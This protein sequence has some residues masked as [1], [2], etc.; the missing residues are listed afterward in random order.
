M[1]ASNFYFFKLS[2]QQLNLSFKSF[3]CYFIFYDNVALINVAYFS[4]SRAVIVRMLVLLPFRSCGV[5]RFE[6]TV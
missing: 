1:Q 3:C 2:R 6:V 5:H 4:Y